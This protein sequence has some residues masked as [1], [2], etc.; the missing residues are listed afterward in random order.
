MVEGQVRGGGAD[1][2]WLPDVPNI[3]AVSPYVRLLQSLRSFAMTSYERVGATI[4]PFAFSGV[5][6]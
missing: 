5:E 3:Q 6:G 1:E 2:T 4:R